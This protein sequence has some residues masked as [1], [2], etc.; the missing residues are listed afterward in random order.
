VS[1][2]RGGTEL[3]ALAPPV[4]PNVLSQER[5]AIEPPIETVVIARLH[6]KTAFSIHKR[7]SKNSQSL[8]RVAI[9]EF[10]A[11]V[12]ADGGRIVYWPARAEP[13]RL[14]AAAIHS[15]KHPELSTVAEDLTV[16]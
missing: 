9:G 2:F 1:S 7:R 10:A 12:K 3:P 14:D 13:P 4:D 16:G 15:L 11:S 6:P 5:V 8:K